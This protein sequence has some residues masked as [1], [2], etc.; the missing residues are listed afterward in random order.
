VI[1]RDVVRAAA[2]LAARHAWADLPEGM[3]LWSDESQVQSEGDLPRV[4]L[5]SVSHVPEGPVSLRRS[6]N[7]EGLLATRML[8]T[9]IWTVQCKTE[10]WKLNSPLNNNPVLF[11]HRMR[12]GWY[13]DEVTRA[14]LDPASPESSRTPVKMVQEVGQILTVNQSIKGHT[15][16]VHLFEIEFRYVDRDADPTVVGVIESASLGGTFAATPATLTTESQDPP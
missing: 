15:L 1:A 9:F 6:P 3:V 7:A 4:T 8:Q 13:L 16:P 10:G 11:T 2:L 14:L 5:S 12:F